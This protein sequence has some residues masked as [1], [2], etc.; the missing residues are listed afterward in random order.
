MLQPR[1]IFVHYRNMF[2][3]TRDYII[4]C[5]DTITNF[6]LH[7]DNVSFWYVRVTYE[8]YFLI[9]LVLVRHY[10]ILRIT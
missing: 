5:F 6:K 8:S 7:E 1:F 2:F 10:E 3:K 4:T 9:T